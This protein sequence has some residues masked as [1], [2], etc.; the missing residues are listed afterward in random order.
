MAQPM[1]VHFTIHRS[2]IEKKGDNPADFKANFRD[3]TPR[4]PSL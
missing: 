2:H 3:P 1:K 4:T